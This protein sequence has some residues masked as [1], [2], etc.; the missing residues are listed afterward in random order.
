MGG[1]GCLR[2]AFEGRGADCWV[3]DSHWKRLGGTVP[4]NDGKLPAALQEGLGTV[5]EWT[6]Q[7]PS[8]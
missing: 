5:S 1:A 7:G 6:A 2:H 4:G 3:K 8:S